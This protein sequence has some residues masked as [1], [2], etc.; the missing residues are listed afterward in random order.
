MLVFF[1]S[2]ESRRHYFSL[3]AHN[4]AHR[5]S[6]LG[7]GV[8]DSKVSDG[9]PLATPNTTVKCIGVDPLDRMAPNYSKPILVARRKALLQ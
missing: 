4:L 1:I 3:Y 6:V 2:S 8:G 5:A 7:I 9:H